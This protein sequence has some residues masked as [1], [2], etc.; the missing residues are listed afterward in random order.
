MPYNV[1]IV[2]DSATMRALVRKVL[3][4]SGFALGDCFEG[5]NGREALEVLNRCRID[6]VLSDIHM[7]E[8][9]GA[10][11]VQALRHH[12]RWQAIPVVLISTESREEV[13]ASACRWGIQG[14]I[15]KPFRPETIRKQLTAILGEVRAPDAGNLAGCDF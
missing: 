9:D 11:L 2:D 15:K 5:A 1:L 4:I 6:L 7:P 8:M 3:A 12:P 14:Y 10:A 13:L